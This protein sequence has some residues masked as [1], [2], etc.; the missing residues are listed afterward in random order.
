MAIKRSKHSVHKAVKKEG[1]THGRF[2]KANLIIFAVVFAAI[3]GYIIY[4]SFAA[5]P[6]CT[7]ADVTTSTF[8]SRVSGAAAG[9]VLCLTSGNYGTWSGTNKA[10]TI[11]AQTGASPQ[12]QI[13]FGSGDANFTLDGMT[14]MG[15]PI[16]AG[17][18]NI[19]IKNSTFSSQLDMEGSMTNIVIDHNTL[20]Y[21]VGVATHG[22]CGGANSKIFLSTSGSSPGAAATISNND[23]E[24]GDLDGIHVGGGSGDMI[25]VRL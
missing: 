8:A 7:G 4:S 3:G 1:F 5:S 17:A 19:T 25:L 15:G 14:G 20:T 24:N 21:P 6:T 13:S 10:I 22:S 12:M 16:S 23:I 18:S 11:T 9:D 2:S